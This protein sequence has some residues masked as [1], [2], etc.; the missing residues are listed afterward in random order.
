V[1][2]SSKRFGNFYREKNDFQHAEEFYERALNAYDE[3]E[4]DINSKEVNEERATFYR[5]RGENV[6]ARTCSKD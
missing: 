2:R 4:I 5:L 6:K 3:A 1:A